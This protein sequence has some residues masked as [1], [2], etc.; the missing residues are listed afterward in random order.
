MDAAA[1]RALAAGAG[2]DPAVDSAAVA[3]REFT[4]RPLD[5]MVAKLMPGGLYVDVKSQADAAQFRSRGLE[6]WRL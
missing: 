3:H 1:P 4:Q 2:Q 6:V 5:D